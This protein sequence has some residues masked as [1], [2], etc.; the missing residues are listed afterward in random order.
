M[1]YISDRIR[2][3]SVEQFDNLSANSAISL[4]EAWAICRHSDPSESKNSERNSESVLVAAFDRS[5]LH[6]QQLPHSLAF[7]NSGGSFPHGVLGPLLNLVEANLVL[8]R[9]SVHG[10][11]ELGHAG[12]HRL[13]DLV[14]AKLGNRQRHRFVKRLGVHFNGMLQA[15]Q[16]LIA[17]AATGKSHNPKYTYS[18]FV[19]VE[20]FLEIF[21]H[22]LSLWWR[23]G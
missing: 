9:F 3:G 15:V 13:V 12:W 4:G 16:V 22:G 14:L 21:C 2:P 1:H 20:Q 5:V 17:D 8:D 7:N 19:R 6:S 23:T 11:G 10:H 18:P